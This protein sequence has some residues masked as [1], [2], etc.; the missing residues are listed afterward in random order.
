MEIH[1][2]LDNKTM[3]MKYA[4]ILATSCFLVLQVLACNFIQAPE[5][6]V[7]EKS[8]IPLTI[9]EKPE[10]VYRGT[11]TRFIIKTTPGNSCNAAVVY[12]VKGKETW[13]A[14]KLPD[15]IADQNGLCSWD[16]LV[17]ENADAGEAG[18]RGT[19]SQ[20]GEMDQYIEPFEFC[21]EKCSY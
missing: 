4:K 17:P 8:N 20:T 10:V 15:L 2:E 19:I 18:L 16:W 6:R 14:S 3:S 5:R 7:L 21:V 12:S 13:E 11:T 1:E 9:I